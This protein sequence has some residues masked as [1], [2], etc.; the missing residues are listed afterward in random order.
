MRRL[1]VSTSRAHE[2]DSFA[3]RAHAGAEIVIDEHGAV[4]TWSD[5]VQELLGFTSPEILGK[6]ASSLLATDSSSPWDG[7][8]PRQGFSAPVVLR[9]RDG[10]VKACRLRIRPSSRPSG[11]W[12]VVVS[13]A[14]EEPDARAIDVAVLGALFKDSPSSLCVY[15]VDL[16]LRRFNPA[17]EGMQGVFREGSLGLMPHEL[18]PDSNSV[19]FEARMKDVLRSG[20]PHVGFE[21]RGRPPDDPDHEHIFSNSVFRLEDD[22]GRVVGLATTAVEITDQRTAE[23][24]IA[25]LADASALIGASLDVMATGQELA[26]ITVPRF[27]D[28]ATV[29]VFAPV[30]S[31]DEPDPAQRDLRRVGLRCAAGPAASHGTTTRS[32]QPRFPY[33]VDPDRLVA[34]GPRRGETLLPGDDGEPLYPRAGRQSAHCLVVPMQARRTL[35]GAVTFYRMG[36]TSAFSDFDVL[37]ARDLASRAALSIDNARRYTREHS[38]VRMLQRRFLPSDTADQSAVETSHYFAPATSGTNWFDVIPV[39]GARVA[40]VVGTTNE[41][42]LSGAAVMGRLGAAVHALTDLDLSPDEVLA[43]MDTL[44]QRITGDGGPASAD[45]VS[46]EVTCVYALYDPASG[47]LSLASAGHVLPLV[48]EPGGHVRTLTAPV[49]APLGSADRH[50]TAKDFTLPAGSTLAFYTPA[51][52]RGGQAAGDESSL[53][54][55]ALH[56]AAGVPLPQLRNDIGQAWSD[57]QALPR[58]TLVLLAR[59]QR[60]GEDQMSIWDLPSDPAVVATARSLV[61]RQLATWGLEETAFVTELVVSELVTNAIRYAEGPIH[62]RV[63]RDHHALICEVSD[64]NATAPHLRYARSGDEGG[65]GLFLI[66]QLTQ[67]W[68]TR[69]SNTG[70][71]IWTE[72]EVA[73]EEQT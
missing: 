56:S 65:R 6:P 39:S 31:G 36:R 1:D 22:L 37:T 58:G 8:G 4:A 72:Q 24:H 33:P 28:A 3:A 48:A 25:L 35:I 70:K 32:A 21:K 2:P 42:G 11:S 55:E 18:W 66:A 30:I 10:R 71:T 27:A 60:L 59:T 14:A 40:L 61:Q 13:P 64:T 41:D 5:E 53:L 50:S 67:R 57:E 9:C 43:R 62:L 46:P 23:E 29:D 26:D 47:S 68:G 34:D 20:V 49:G 45:T 63:I 15:D 19:E 73:E 51:T 38:A 16:R 52:A 7:T 17:A 54:A 44:A 12:T 69:F